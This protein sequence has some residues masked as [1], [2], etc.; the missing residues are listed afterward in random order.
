MGFIQTAFLGALAA[1]AIPVVIHLIFRRRSRRVDLGTIRFLKVVLKENAR[2]RR[3]QRY[4]L[5]GLRMACVALL[6]LLFARPYLLAEQASDKDRFVAI[7]VDRSATMALADRDGRLLDQ[8]VARAR[9]VMEGTNR[10]TQVEVAFFDHAVRPLVESQGEGGLT[11][12]DAPRET[13]A[14]TD[15]GAAVNWARDLS[16]KSPHR[17]REVHIITDLQRSGL[18]WTEAEPFPDDVHVRVHDLGTTAG[19]NVAVTGARAPRTLIRPGETVNVTATVLNSSDFPQEALPVNLTLESER[20]QHRLHEQV[21]IAPGETATV[22]FEI[23]GLEA[24]LWQGSVSVSA[25]DDLAFDNRRHLAVM[26]APRLRVLLVDGDPQSSPLLSETYFLETAL[27]LAA[28]GQTFADTPFE[29][30]VARI[31]DGQPLPDLA[32]ADLVVLAN[33]GELAAGDAGRLADFVAAGGGLMVFTGENVTAESAASLGELAAGTVGGSRRSNDL[34]VRLRGWDE[35]HPVFTPFNDP[36]HGDLRRLSFYAY[37][38]IEPAADA[39]VLAELRTGDPVLIERRHG[40]GKV[41]WFASAADR[42]WGDWTRSRLFLP[43]VHQTLG[44]LSGLAEGGPV[45]ETLFD[46]TGTADGDEVP[47]VYERD[48][49]W[50]VINPS[51]RESETDRCR[52]EEFAQRF[53]VKFDD[54]QEAEASL[55]DAPRAR[56]MEL[57]DDEIWHW[58]VFG[59]LGMLAIEGLLA[60]RTTA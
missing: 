54:P 20:R 44:Y 48:G 46:G 57:R 36:Q 59:L 35:K 11:G 58:L 41:L 4:V 2:R 39:R 40:K 47:G 22:E 7:L 6:A 30:T 21:N 14:G 34:P 23:P 29:P 31:E 55:A 13:Y 52:P 19:N 45:R 9:E 51:P 12:L 28:P 37:T 24:G 5:L 42:Q 33:V 53:Q 25:S 56:S 10:Q 49:Y 38:R 32:R 8:A 16:V 3:I 43:L 18:D 50:E 17:R 60:N 26:A 27:R 1:V 15:Y